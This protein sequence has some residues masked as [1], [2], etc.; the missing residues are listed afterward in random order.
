MKIDLRKAS[1]AEKEEMEIFFLP[2]YSLEINPDE[3]LNN[4]LKSTI[5]LKQTPKNHK[6]MIKSHMILYRKTRRWLLVFITTNQ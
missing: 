6:Q 3:Y 4:D 2:S 1:T 5:G